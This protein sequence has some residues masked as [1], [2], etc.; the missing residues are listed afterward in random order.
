MNDTIETTTVEA[1]LHKLR[2]KGWMVAV[3]N[4]Y[5]L[6]GETFMFY[7]FTHPSGLWAKGEGRSDMEA[8]EEAM[9]QMED[10]P[11]IVAAYRNA[12]ARILNHFNVTCRWP[13]PD[14]GRES[15]TAPLRIVSTRAVAHDHK[16]P[17]GP[18]HFTGCW[19]CNAERVLH[20]ADQVLKRDPYGA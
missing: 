13:C 10:A 1:L 20:D 3:H 12:I 8:I 9:A 17:L 5:R 7:L 18:Q 15:A 4:D 2:V 14:C 6:K 11:P 19:R 16:T